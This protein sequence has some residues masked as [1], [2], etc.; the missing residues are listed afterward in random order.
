MSSAAIQ[1]LVVLPLNSDCDGLRQQ[2]PLLRVLGH[3]SLE[4]NLLALFQACRNVPPDI[5][6]GLGLVVRLVDEA[7]DL[8]AAAQVLE[9]WVC[10][11]LAQGCLAALIKRLDIESCNYKEKHQVA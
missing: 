5:D 7:V 8:V 9:L 1:M 4:Q 11:E 3:R 10:F 6:Q 2:V